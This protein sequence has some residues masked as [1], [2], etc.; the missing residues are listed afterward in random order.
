MTNNAHPSYH[1]SRN[2]LGMKP[3]ILLDK[4]IT[5]DEYQKRLVE[6]QPDIE[7][8]YLRNLPGQYYCRL[9]E[10]PCTMYTGDSLNGYECL[11]GKDED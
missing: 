3:A 4:E 10:K 2:I 8:Q 5:T 11:Y 7:C 1:H 6:I 9:C